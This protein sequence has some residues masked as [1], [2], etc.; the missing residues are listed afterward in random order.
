[1]PRFP[2]T[3]GT[4]VPPVVIPPPPPPFWGAVTSASLG[5]HAVHAGRMPRFEHVWPQESGAEQQFVKITKPPFGTP[6]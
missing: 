4:T 2:L 3:L 1:M 5:W 6:D